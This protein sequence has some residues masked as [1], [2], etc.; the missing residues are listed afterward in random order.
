MN[1]AMLIGFFAIYSTVMLLWINLFSFQEA[2]EYLYSVFEPI[3]WGLLL[4][5]QWFAL[6]LT[7]LDRDEFLYLYFKG[8]VFV[9]LVEM[10]VDT[11]IG[12][13]SDTRL[14][15][16]QYLDSIFS[17]Y[18]SLS[19]VL[20]FLVPNY[21]LEILRERRLSTFITSKTIEHYVVGTFL[22]ICVPFLVLRGGID[23]YVVLFGDLSE[24]LNY[25]QRAWLVSKL[26]V[27]AI[28]P[29][30]M[31]YVVARNVYSDKDLKA[32]LMLAACLVLSVQIATENQELHNIIAGIMQ[33]LILLVIGDFVLNSG[34]KSSNNNL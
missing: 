26:M 6:L 23:S 5:G 34:S 1:K 7:R 17:I 21:I 15:Q 14:F 31:L 19:V 3:K 33:G 4:G 25:I 29:V 2:N 24:Q 16:G 11:A 13:F 18:I 10:L 22:A 30:I 12:V 32:G 28:V 27:L 9:F 8:W 20:L